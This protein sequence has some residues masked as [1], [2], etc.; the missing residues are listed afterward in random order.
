M[1]DNLDQQLERIFKENRENDLPNKTKIVVENTFASLEKNM[2]KNKKQ[3]VHKVAAC[4]MI[5]IVGGSI[6]F[7]KEIKNL[8]QNV[9]NYDVQGTQGV[10]VAAD[11]GY[12]Q[13]VDM[14]YIEVDNTKFKIDYVTMDDTNLAINFN[15]LL[16]VNA[17]DFK[18]IS[19][20]NMKIYDDSGNIIYTEEEKYP[21]DG[22]SLGIGI[23]KPVYINGSRWKF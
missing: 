3:I 11:K 13:N 7:A 14:E 20:Y 4:F 1:K 2:Y 18:G 8:A 19:F 15:F 16:D 17:E 5:F 12:I 21:N 9:F 10:Q 23:V 6:V 22:I